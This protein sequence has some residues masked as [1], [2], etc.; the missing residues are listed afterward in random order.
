[1]GSG[2]KS[3]GFRFVKARR[4]GLNTKVLQDTKTQTLMPIIHNKIIP[5]SIVYMDCYHSYNA[6]DVSEFHHLRINHS[7]HFAEQKTNHIHDIENF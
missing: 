4:K 2:R 6:L 1:M 5:D 3:G 7:S